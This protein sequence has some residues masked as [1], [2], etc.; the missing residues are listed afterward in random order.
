MSVEGNS[1][2]QFCSRHA[3]AYYSITDWEQIRPLYPDEEQ[4]RVPEPVSSVDLAIVI[5]HSLIQLFKEPV[6]PSVIIQR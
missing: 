1:R 5:I 6:S 3:Y 4:A 2:T